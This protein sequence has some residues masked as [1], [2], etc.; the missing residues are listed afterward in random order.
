M[1]SLANVGCATASCVSKASLSPLL[2]SI[3]LRATQDLCANYI[4]SKDDDGTQ[5]EKGRPQHQ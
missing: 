3:G 1:T 4:Q 5:D 2:V